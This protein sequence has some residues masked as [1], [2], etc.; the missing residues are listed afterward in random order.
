MNSCLCL[1]SY[2]RPRLF[3]RVSWIRL[4]LFASCLVLQSSFALTSIGSSIQSPIASSASSSG[5]STITSSIGSSTGLPTAYIDPTYINPTTQ[6]TLYVYR[7]D[8]TMA[9]NRDFAS[10]N[11]NRDQPVRF[12]GWD[13]SE[14]LN[15]ARQTASS[16]SDI[17]L[18]IS[19]VS[20]RDPAHNWFNLC[21]NGAQANSRQT[22]GAQTSGAT[23][24]LVG[25]V[26]S[27]GADG[28]TVVV[29]PDVPR[30]FWGL[31]SLP[32][33]VGAHCTATV[34]VLS[35]QSKQVLHQQSVTVNLMPSPMSHYP[36]I[37]HPVFHLVNIDQT[38]HQ[39]AFRWCTT[40][41][42]PDHPDQAIRLNEKL[43]DASLGFSPSI[44]YYYCRAGSPCLLNKDPSG[45]PPSNF[46]PGDQTTPQPRVNNYTEFKFYQQD[47]QAIDVEAAALGCNVLGQNHQ[48]LMP[49]NYSLQQGE[50][51]QSHLTFNQVITYQQLR[52]WGFDL[53]N[54]GQPITVTLIWQG[55]PIQ[56]RLNQYHNL[57]G[58]LQTTHRYLYGTYEVVMTPQQTASGVLSSFYTFFGTGTFTKNYETGTRAAAASLSDSQI[59]HW[60][61]AKNL[62]T[63]FVMSWRDTDL[64]DAFQITLQDQSIA[65]PNAALIDFFVEPSG[66]ETLATARRVKTVKATTAKTTEIAERVG[67]A[68]TAATDRII[69]A[70]W[71]S[72]THQFHVPVVP[73]HTYNI[74][75]RHYQKTRP[76]GHATDF[77]LF[78][79]TA[80]HTFTDWGYTWHEIDFEFP[81]AKAPY[82]HVIPLSPYY[83]EG[84]FESPLVL[85]N[86]LDRGISTNAFFPGYMGRN[87]WGAWQKHRFCPNP[88]DP[89]CQISQFSIYDGQ[90]HRLT[91]S[92][93]PRRIRYYVD[94]ALITTV[95]IDH[96]TVASLDENYSN[97]QY[98]SVAHQMQFSDAFI[99]D[100][101]GQTH[102]TVPQFISLNM[103]TP[104]YIDN[105]GADYDGFLSNQYPSASDRAAFA[106]K[107]T[108]QS[109]KW[110]P[111]VESNSQIANGDWYSTA[112]QCEATGD[113]YSGRVYTASGDDQGQVPL[114]TDF[115]ALGQWVVDQS[116]KASVLYQQGWMF[117]PRLS[118]DG[119]NSYFIQNNVLLTPRGLTLCLQDQ[120]TH[121][122]YRGHWATGCDGMSGPLLPPPGE[123]HG[124]DTDIQSALLVIRATLKQRLTL[125]KHNLFSGVIPTMPMGYP[126]VEP[127]YI[128]NTWTDGGNNTYSCNDPALGENGHSITN[129]FCDGMG[130]FADPR[131]VPIE[132]DGNRLEATFLVQIQTVDVDGAP[133]RFTHLYSRAPVIVNG[134]SCQVTYQ[135]PTLTTAEAAN[136]TPLPFG[137]KAVALMPQ[138]TYVVD[139]MVD[140]QS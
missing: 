36:V 12:Y 92:W 108:Y 124:R 85:P 87:H 67:A 54:T 25:N 34:A 103:W 136:M 63:E 48:N 45:Y 14:V 39:P 3:S 33:S 78:N 97:R 37:E 69:S 138:Q 84:G 137:E 113:T 58:A 72:A 107:A 31:P 123:Y 132:Q 118:F 61:L 30:A 98:A 96:E 4:S 104:T 82:G 49:V 8:Y 102:F 38:P 101:Y 53:S 130:W 51:T 44:N 55:E 41:H 27:V 52:Q 47:H 115:A 43:L 89:A 79:V 17:Y 93:S 6:P 57:S 7:S 9:G 80:A 134:Q 126:T 88:N 24:C 105:F 26:L 35:H 20:C 106:A 91:L 22:S 119:N 86:E 29:N 46:T 18:S 56:G 16:P 74:A 112:S 65:D 131:F 73:G 128:N 71:P 13:F 62:G 110:T 125:D 42:E 66:P 116:S 133:L 10:D 50:V 70:A 32:D 117:A 99:N 19:N 135:A 64:Q 23:A 95:P 129:K 94:G 90:P 15:Q 40:T 139:A 109:V 81:F 140:C 68:K 2:V 11:Q 127:G 83:G 28:Q 120:W 21:P 122:A 59:T 77:S 1:H 5:G 60:Q 111:C 76:P 75:I 114:N 100:L 121:Q